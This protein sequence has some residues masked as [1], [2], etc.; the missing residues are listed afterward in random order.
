[1]IMAG[2]RIDFYGDFLCPHCYFTTLGLEK[3]RRE[4][5]AQLFWH[6]YPFRPDAKAADE[7][8][9]MA[10]IIKEKYGV[11]V[12]PGPAVIKTYKAHLA[13]KYAEACGNSAAMHSMLCKAYWRD[14]LDISD[15]EIL[16]TLADELGLNG[17][18]MLGAIN[19]DKTLVKAVDDDLKA[20]KIFDIE[21]V[22][23][24]VFEERMMI[25]GSQNYDELVKLVS[26]VK[27]AQK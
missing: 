9:Y 12:K 7:R 8:R 22:P 11:D 3:L 15:P 4:H 17:A 2:P 24:L 19:N 14:G 5:G 16:K 26:K 21:S 20:A 25:S 18:E 23:S 6:T 13:D 27:A 10:S 1:M